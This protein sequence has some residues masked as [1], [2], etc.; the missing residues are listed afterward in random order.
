MIY[1]DGY[2]T[3]ENMRFTKC[4]RCG[5]EEYSEKAA[6]CRICGFQAYNECE[7]YYDNDHEE[8]V[9]HRNYGNARFC[10][11]CGQPTIL[12][13]EKLLRHYTDVQ[14]DQTAQDDEE[15]PFTTDS[16]PF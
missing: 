8:Y 5:N 7:G 13:K 16:F 15:L 3:D 14:F 12:F 2:E 1:R 6:Y 4:P 11:F 9:N 10:E